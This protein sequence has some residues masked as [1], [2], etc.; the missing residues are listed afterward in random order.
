M[1]IIYYSTMRG[2][3]QFYYGTEILMNSDENPGDHGLIRTEFPGGWPDHSK[4]AFTGDG[5]SKDE[6]QTQLFFKE[7]LNWRKNNKVIHK[8]KL[9]QFSPKENGIYSFFRVLDNQLVWV[10]FNRNNSSRIID[11]SRFKELI[12]NK[13]FGYDVLNKKRVSIN[14]SIEIDK[15]SALIIEIE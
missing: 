10:I 3:P 12:S 15:K 5:L 14:N 8:G 9:I 2:I 11:T 7:L 4:N 1:G 6:K 13:E